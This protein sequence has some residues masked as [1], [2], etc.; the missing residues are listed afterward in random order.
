MPSLRSLAKCIARL[1]RGSVRD[2]R[3]ASAVEYGLIAALIV[4]AMIASFK[5]LANTTVNMWGN[6]NAKIA[7]ATGY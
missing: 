7:N 1:I 3:G 6:T 5:E 2:Q 4:L